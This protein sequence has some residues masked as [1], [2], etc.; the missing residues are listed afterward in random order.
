[1]NKLKLLPKDLLITTNQVDHADWNFR[2][3]LGF[4]QRKR[5]RLINSL[6]GNNYYDQVLEIGYGSG[7]FMPELSKHSNKLFGIDIHPFNEKVQKIL[8]NYKVHTD[9]FQ[10]SVSQMPFINESF[11]LIV[12][13][14]A[15]EFVEDKENACKEILRVLN[16][17]GIFIMVTPG[18]SP[19]LD[20]GLKLLTN[21]SANKDYGHKR[22]YVLPI[23]MEYFSISQRIVF[24]HL[25]LNWFPPIYSAYILKPKY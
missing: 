20:L 22:K 18:D 4:I 11:D 10:G 21:V 19:F 5:F 13:V 1:M 16:K 14:S 6:I 17:D 8:L 25:F 3:V 9:L 23:I 15:F 12:S 2:P 24:P 7:I